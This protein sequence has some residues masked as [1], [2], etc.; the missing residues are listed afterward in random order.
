MSYL[1]DDDIEFSRNNEENRD[2][3]VDGLDFSIPQDENSLD[4]S[5]D[6]Y[7]ASVTEESQGRKKR[8]LRASTP[9]QQACNLTGDEEVVDLTDLSTESNDDGSSPISEQPQVLNDPKVW[10][11]DLAS[12]DDIEKVI[13]FKTEK[14]RA[15]AL[16]HIRPSG[17]IAF[18]A[19]YASYIINLDALASS[20]DIKS[21]SLGAYTGLSRVSRYYSIKTRVDGSS[22]L[23][24]ADVD[25]HKS[26]RKPPSWDLVLTCPHGDCKSSGKLLQRKIYLAF[27]K[28]G[29]KQQ[30][31]VVSYAWKGRNMPH[32]F[33]ILAH[34]NK[35]RRLES[36]QRTPTSTF[37]KGR[38]QL[39]N[40][41]VSNAV[42]A[43]LGQS[44]TTDTDQ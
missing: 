16:G 19:K 39:L 27:D 3:I 11:M 23:E 9:L 38:A 1:F 36:Y 22:E 34:G 29:C 10:R 26:N 7:P 8:P 31:A 25:P 41:S 42:A 13:I 37:E 6:V 35:R 24:R 28:N 14:V 44:G 12:F 4:L 15:S 2:L 33:Q 43:M 18:H 30:L 32:P 17:K 21:D 5:D 40:M 20:N